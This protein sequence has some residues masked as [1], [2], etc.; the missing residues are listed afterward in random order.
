[1]I[2]E[3]I[4]KVYEKTRKG[5]SYRALQIMVKVFNENLDDYLIFNPQG[6]LSRL[7]KEKE[8]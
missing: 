4:M 3:E 7:T 8:T 5:M 6:C 2:P 1:M